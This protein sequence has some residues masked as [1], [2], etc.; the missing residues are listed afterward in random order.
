MCFVQ[1][2]D[3][4]ITDRLIPN[5]EKEFNGNVAMLNRTTHIKINS[6][7]FRDREFSV[8]KPNSTFRII[9]L[10]DSFTFGI[11]IE[12][13]ETFPKLLE[14][15]LNEVKNG[16][17]YEVMNF[18]VPGYNTLDEIQFFKD[19]GLK[20]NPNMV[21]VGFIDNDIDDNVEMWQRISEG[22]NVSN[23]T[24]K[25]GDIESQIKITNLQ[26]DIIKQYEHEIFTNESNFNLHWNK[27]VAQ[28]LSELS[29]LSKKNN[30]TV[31]IVMLDTNPVQKES[32]GLDTIANEYGWHVV[33]LEQVLKSYPKIELALSENDWH[34]NY[35]AS[36][37]VAS[38]IYGYLIDKNLIK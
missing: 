12:S 34:F 15:K 26:L 2:D 13:N 3:P 5:C 29:A 31:T 24:I 22:I 6:D 4:K 33:K 36:Q 38:Q 18:G 23:N 32:E 11:G 37:I 16:K 30:F 25:E 35:F 21:V 1:N 28:P 10:G 14:N 17:S 7:G 20:Y 8:E 19:V 9:F 27:I